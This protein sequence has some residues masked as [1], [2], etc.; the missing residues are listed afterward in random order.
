MLRELAGDGG[1]GVLI[2]MDPDELTTIIQY[3]KKI[4]EELQQNAVPNIEKFGNLE[5]YTAGKAKKA[6]EVYPK[7]NEKILDLV[8][9]YERASSLVYDIL[10]KM[11]QTDQT[12]AEQIIAKLG[13]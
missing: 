10:I 13:V 7:A 2:S 12:I 5:Y 4:S 1:S 3:L 9:N 11:I 6:M 8:E